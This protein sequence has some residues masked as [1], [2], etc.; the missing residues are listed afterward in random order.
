MSEDREAW[1]S[2]PAFILAAVGAAV[3][4]GNIW[5][6]PALAYEYGGGAF[7]IPYLLALVFI[8]LPLLLLELALGQHLQT[9][10]V[11]VFGSI[12]KR[13]R[14]VGLIA[15]LCGFTVTGYYVQLLAWVV[16]IFVES[17]G[18][19]SEGWDNISSED[20]SA[21]FFDHIVGE[22]TLGDDSKLPTRIVG[23]N[24]LYLA[25]SWLSVGLC[26][27]FGVKWTGRIAYFTMG[28]PI[29]LLLAF[30][31]RA[32][33]LEGAGEG[34]QSYIGQWDLAVLAERPDV[35]STAVSQIFFSLGTTFGVLTAFGSHCPSGSP[36]TENAYIIGFSN[37]MFSV[38]S[39]FA[40]FGSLGYLKGYEGADDIADVATA[41]P[42]LI[43]GALPAVLSTLPGGI[44]LVRVLFFTL[45]ILGL[46]SAFAFTEAIITVIRDSEVGNNRST[47]MITGAVCFAGFLT[48]IIYTSDA[49]MTFL[50][51]VDFYVN[52][53]MIM[54]GFCKTLSA[55]WIYGLDNQLATFGPKI[56]YGY[57][58]TT[59]GSVIIACIIWFWIP[60]DTEVVG[61]LL[62]FLSYGV[63]MLICAKEIK[64]FVA[65][66][67]DRGFT[68]K[69]A[70][71][72]LSMGNILQLKTAL[73][74]SVG[75]IPVAWPYLI[76]HFIPQI[77]LVLFFNLTG[78]RNDLG[79]TVFGHYEAFPFVF[80][81]VGIFVVVVAVIIFS[82]GVKRPETF[83]KI[84]SLQEKP[85]GH[86]INGAEDGFDTVYVEMPAK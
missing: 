45:F 7:F 27:A 29:V 70:L 64:D 10:D 26:V 62:L 8:G 57:M 14:G 66:N 56:V 77:L 52:F 30:F 50:D 20:A 61:F 35:W 47:K 71:Y 49:G 36:A 11:G 21:Y 58:L 44:H 32:V 12:N 55:G 51:T 46:D 84:A 86:Y 65:H 42:G 16:R 79:E 37:S 83:E 9:G 40:V 6:F 33:T 31:V 19:M 81:M 53:A 76:K 80:Q 85:M 72:E 82:I 41:G 63:G 18:D 59:F 3:G 2:R 17:F 39:G 23:P 69:S 28:V 74:S 15:V 78:S 67:P 75:K 34:I 54:I 68:V 4:F 73:E 22:E 13:L 25:I 1:S 43:F 38:I 5:R 24:V 48:G 60:Y